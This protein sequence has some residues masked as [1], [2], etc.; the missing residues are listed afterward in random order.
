LDEVYLDP[1][2]DLP[3]DTPLEQ[4]QLSA[5]IRNALTDTEFK[6]IGEVRQAS[7]ETLLSFHN[8]GHGALRY[9]RRLGSSPP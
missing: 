2:S 4:I 9:L 1:T 7:D 8:L 3:D 5:R 6:T